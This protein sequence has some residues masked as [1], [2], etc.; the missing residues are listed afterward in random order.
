MKIICNPCLLL[1]IFSLFFS[2]GQEKQ[3]GNGKHIINVPEDLNEMCH[4]DSVFS[5]VSF[6]HLETKDDY[7]ISHVSDLQVVDSLIYI[8]DNRKRLLVYGKDG[9]FRYEIGACGKGP[10]EFLEVRDF[11]I[12]KDNIELLD[13]KKIITYTLD[14]V[15]KST[16]HFELLDK[17]NADNFCHSPLGG[18]YFWQCS[19]PKGEHADLEK[20]KMYHVDNNLKIQQGY[21]SSDYGTSNSYKRFSINNDTIIIDPFFGDYNVYQINSDG[22]ISSRYYFNF[23]RN[24]YHAEIPIS[25]KKEPH[26]PDESLSNYIV[27][28]ESFFETDKWIHI[29]F[30]FKNKAL[31]LLFNK[32]TQKSYLLSAANPKLQTN[33]IRY[34]GASALADNQ[35]IMPIDAS[36][37][38]IEMERMSPE[39]IKK[40]HLEEYK[41][42]DEFSNPFLVFYKLK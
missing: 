19:P 41:D 22:A 29:S 37:L 40:L 38:Q 13:F 32:H 39:Y 12:N 5:S 4:L 9:K 20:Y 33:E 27:S 36:W 35:L 23:G 25:K 26:K 15:H 2:C 31:N 8:N 11:I 6:I 3:A 34:W 10:G 17:C 16:K 30:A 24:A 42:L 7:L 21:L 14:G 28:C 1:V 18:Y